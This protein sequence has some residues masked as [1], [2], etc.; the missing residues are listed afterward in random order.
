MVQKR[1]VKQAQTDI[2]E[3]FSEYDKKFELT[4]NTQMPSENYE[5]ID[6]PELEK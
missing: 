1:K 6:R 3:N 5:I 2:E 4:G